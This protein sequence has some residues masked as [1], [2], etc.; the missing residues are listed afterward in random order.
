MSQSRS[1]HLPHLEGE[2][3]EAGSVDP[4][5]AFSRYQLFER[6]ASH[7]VEAV[8]AA[9]CALP[10]PATTL[11]PVN[12]R[13]TASWLRLMGES[14][15]ADAEDA[16]NP[17]A[18]AR[19]TIGGP[20]L[21]DAQGVP[22][23]LPDALH[24]G[25]ARFIANSGLR[26]QPLRELRAYQLGCTYRPWPHANPFHAVD[27]PLELKRAS[28]DVIAE[29]FRWVAR[30]RGSNSP[31]EK[32]KKLKKKQRGEKVKVEGRKSESPQVKLKKGVFGEVKVENRRCLKRSLGG[33]EWTS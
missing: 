25:L 12:K 8:F 6:C 13:C 10:M 17:E 23:S 30:S 29:Q 16:D 33:R 19:L 14:A 9:H 24:V 32:P 2:E 5:V 31:R 15:A 3:K 27:R 26:P 7:H 22:V 21:L 18:D 11:I 28:F 1:L 20:V 4:L